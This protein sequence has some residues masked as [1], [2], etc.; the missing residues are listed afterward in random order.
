M[1]GMI[2]AANWKAY[3]ESAAKA[4][5]LFAAAKRLASRTGQEIIL[6]PPPPFLGMLAAGNRSKVAFAAQDVSTATGGAHTGEVTAGT[7]REAG[8]TYAIVGHSE[9]RAAGDDNDIVSLKLQHTLA[10]GLTPIL[11]IGERV[12]DEDAQYLVFLREEISSAFTALSQKERMTVLIAYEPIWAIGKT[13]ADSIGPSDLAEM[14][15]YI[16]KVLSEFLPG[17]GSSRARI[18]Y[19]GSVEADNAGALAQGGIDG[20][21]IGHAAT[22]TESFTKLVRAV[23]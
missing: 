1:K 2:I 8:A 17:K 18:L 4:K 12:R 21:L 19:G 7:A 11:C 10:Q 20:F 3:V 23:V 15:L 5:K 13:A 22:N 6:A 14:V 9:R 16:R